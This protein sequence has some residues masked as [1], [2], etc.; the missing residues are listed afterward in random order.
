MV[1]IC[2]SYRVRVEIRVGVMVRIR[3]RFRFR[4][5]DRE[6]HLMCCCG[7]LPFSTFRLP[8]YLHPNK[9]A[10]VNRT[11]IAPPPQQKKKKGGDILVGWV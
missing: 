8:K 10:N 4:V 5:R 2:D 6:G 9:H 1:F 11:C 7:E 3:F